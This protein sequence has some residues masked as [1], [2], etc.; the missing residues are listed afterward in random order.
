MIFR[1]FSGISISCALILAGFVTIG[2]TE[3]PGNLKFI[4]QNDPEMATAAA[5]AQAGLDGFLSKLDN[6]PA[7]TENYSVKVGIVDQGDG[8]A[9]TGLKN[10]ENVE[11]F[12]L[13]NLRRTPDGFLG[14]IANQPGVARNVSAGQEIAFAKGD[15]FDWMYV[16]GG[17]IVG[18]VTACPILLR[19]P[20]EELEFYRLNYGLEC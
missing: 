16:N 4:P 8:F 19:G 18:N 15:I 2:R 1:K 11:Y 5:K 9:L 3:E 6:P 17:K 12:W 10:V 14:S 13:G 20:K 7:G